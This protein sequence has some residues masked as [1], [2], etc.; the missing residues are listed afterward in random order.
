MF[1]LC[2]KS[3][4]L[5]KTSASRRIHKVAFTL[6][7]AFGVKPLDITGIYTLPK[8]LVMSMCLSLSLHRR[9]NESMC[10][11]TIYRCTFT[12]IF[13]HCYRQHP[14]TIP[15]QSS[16]F[17]QPRFGAPGCPLLVIKGILPLKLAARPAPRWEVAEPT[18]GTNPPMCCIYPLV[19]PNIAGWNIPMFNRK[20]IFIQRVH[21]PAS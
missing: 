9:L 16:T 19:F 12:E 5:K 21:F 11:K 7:L 10:K 2:G 6:K 17:H 15:D 20:Y 1:D 14:Y 4:Y 13:N 3:Y 8:Y 18:R